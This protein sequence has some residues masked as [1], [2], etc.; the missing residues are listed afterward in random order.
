LKG[1]LVR[2]ARIKNT[3]VGTPKSWWSN[4]SLGRIKGIMAGRTPR[5]PLVGT[6]ETPVEED[7]RLKGI[8]KIESFERKGN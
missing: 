8:Q 5:S 2:S 6:G 3:E 4:G 1:S 7:D